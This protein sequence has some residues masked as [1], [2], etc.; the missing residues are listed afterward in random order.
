MRNKLSRRHKQKNADEEEADPPATVTTPPATKQASS[1]GQATLPTISDA[2]PSTSV[3]SVVSSTKTAAST[4]TS[5]SHD[6]SGMSKLGG[7]QQPKQGSESGTGGGRYNRKDDDDE[8]RN[9]GIVG[10]IR[11]SGREGR[12]GLVSP[13]AELPRV[14]SYNPRQVLAINL[15]ADGKKRATDLKYTVRRTTDIP[16]MG[17]TITTLETPPEINAVNSIS[18]LEK[19]IQDS[20]FTLNRLYVPYR[21]GAAGSG[22][23]GPLRP[24]PGC[25]PDRC[26]GASLI[27]WR[28][29]LAPCA[30]GVKIG[31]VDTG[32]DT[33]HPAIPGRDSN[34]V[35]KSFV[36]EG[37]AKANEDHGTGVLS[38]LAGRPQSSTPGLV[39]NAVYRVANAFYAET[40]S[41]PA[42]S[43]TDHMVRALDWLN[44]QEVRIINL[45]FS[46]PRDPLVHH[47]IKKLARKG[48]LMV[49]AAGND[50]PSAPPSF[51][52]AYDEVV[53]VT[54]VDRNL[55][56]YRY[57]NRGDH[58]SIAAPGVGIWTALANRREGPQ[59]GT[60]FA[61]PY[62]T[63][64][65]ALNHALIESMDESLSPKE[66]ALRVLNANAM[67]LGGPQDRRIFGAGLVRAP[68][69][70][71]SP[72]GTS[73]AEK[74]PA[75]AKREPVVMKASISPLLDWFKST[76]V[77]AAT[78]N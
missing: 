65:L 36:P 29:E 66:R 38:V 35:Y 52:A 34:A 28:A 70:C 2:A 40:K 56:P 27:N 55:T 43:E 71:P 75:A 24:G 45:S 8:G 18:Q 1:K 64:V 63:G 67:K 46:G 4:T 19:E 60:S 68:D 26:F 39:P 41:G 59:T 53:A 23:G 47:L 30:Q 58:I 69:A 77:R 5:P 16:S 74:A 76:T 9:G 57:A 72:T 61:A 50:G 22:S 42:I 48:I 33:T 54:A 17:A 12:G 78:A 49:A 37:S 3:E 62:V 10:A 13:L 32:V 25:D 11:N 6:N 51:P 14:G 73:V 20:A 21:L 31:I 44:Q 15:S 7:P